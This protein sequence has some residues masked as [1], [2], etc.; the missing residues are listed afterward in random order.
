MDQRMVDLEGPSC[1]QV[2]LRQ[3][4]GE[5]IVHLCN[6]APGKELHFAMGSGGGRVSLSSFSGSVEIKAR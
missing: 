1:V 5:R 3:K 4:E 2:S 6:N